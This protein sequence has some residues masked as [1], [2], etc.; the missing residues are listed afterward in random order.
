MPYYPNNNSN[1]N[2]NSKNS[3]HN[4]NIHTNVRDKNESL[5]PDGMWAGRWAE[6][7]ELTDVP[8]VTLLSVSLSNT[9]GTK[10]GP[11]TP[12]SAPKHPKPKL[13]Q[14]KFPGARGFFRREFGRAGTFRRKICQG[15]AFDG[16]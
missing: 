6:F 12:K 1:N 10:S 8:P 4:D 13:R 3:F 2:N 15:P 11:L 14:P 9:G 7:T 5:L 16:V